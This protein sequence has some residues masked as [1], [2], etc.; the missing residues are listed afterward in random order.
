VETRKHD[1]GLVVAHAARL[2]RALYL[3]EV[4]DSEVEDGD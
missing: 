1:A 4:E 3:S 2:G